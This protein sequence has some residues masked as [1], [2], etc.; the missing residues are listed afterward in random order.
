MLGVRY[1]PPDEVG[2]EPELTKLVRPN[3]L[4]TELEGHEYVLHRWVEIK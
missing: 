4:K 1:N 3:R 2:K